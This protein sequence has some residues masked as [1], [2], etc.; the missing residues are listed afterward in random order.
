VTHLG[1]WGCGVG[2]DGIPVDGVEQEDSGIGVGEQFPQE[3]VGGLVLL[4]GVGP[5]EV[6]VLLV[7]GHLAEEVGAVGEVLQVVEFPLHEAVDGFHVGVGIGAAGGS[8]AMAGG[9]LL[10][11]GVGE[12]PVTPLAGVAVVLGP[13]VGLDGD[14]AEVEAVLLEV[15]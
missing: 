8:K 12:T 6:E 14:G 7:E 15:S 4:P 1:G 5:T 13:V 10:G 3:L 2:E 11:D 9:E